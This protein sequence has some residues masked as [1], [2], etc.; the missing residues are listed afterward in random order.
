MAPS[1]PD[2]PRLIRWRQTVGDRL[3]SLRRGQRVTQEGLAEA[4]G[5][6]RKTINRW[7]RGHHAMS[8]DHAWRIADVLDV[9]PNWLFTDDWTRPAESAPRGGAAGGETP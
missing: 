9:P 6:D 8:I 2:D 4:L 1:D 7:E 3:R 5:V